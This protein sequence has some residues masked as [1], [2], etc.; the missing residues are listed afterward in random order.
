MLEKG[1]QVPVLLE[2]A[3]PPGVG[4]TPQTPGWI[5][6]ALLLLA[7]G[8][9]IVVRQLAHR[10]RDRWR[11][12]ACALLVKQQTADGWIA[13]IKRIL[14]VHTPRDAQRLRLEPEVLLAPLP[15]DDELRALLCHKYCQRD[16]RLTASHNQRLQVQI[17]RWLR[18]LPYV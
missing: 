8:L 2:P 15:V 12:E 13:L 5:L 3:L 1:F 16:N 9:A 18:E 10:R 11:R 17:G 7:L 14:L 6:L 4:W